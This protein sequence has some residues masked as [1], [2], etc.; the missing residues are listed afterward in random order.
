VGIP[1]NHPA[2]VEAMRRGLIVETAA[3]TGAIPA[4]PPAG[5]SERDFQARVIDLAE[6]HGWECFH[7]YDSRRSAAGFPDLVLVRYGLL[8]FAEL[9]VK[10]NK[11][12]AA[13]ERWLEL[14]AA[15]PGVRVRRWRETDWM[16][17]VAELTEGGGP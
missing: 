7:V 9:K 14:L 5:C 2:I 15:V 6:R 13:Q 17:I 11:T 10:K 3:A 1:A 4:A 8:L 16:T 12:T